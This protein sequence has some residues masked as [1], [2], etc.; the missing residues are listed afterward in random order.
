MKS[1]QAKL[2]RIW[3]LIRK[4][5]TLCC[6]IC[7]GYM[8]ILSQSPFFISSYSRSIGLA[9]NSPSSY[10]CD[11]SWMQCFLFWPFLKLME[12]RL[13]YYSNVSCFKWDIYVI[14]WNIIIIVGRRHWPGSNYFASLM[15]ISRTWSRL[16][17]ARRCTSIRYVRER[18]YCIYWTYMS[19]V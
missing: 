13:Q 2:L 12:H 16:T 10:N 9:I 8:Y 14:S 7:K 11:W 3:I 18:A 19:V 5:W 1:Q 4:I 15:S 6:H 17:N